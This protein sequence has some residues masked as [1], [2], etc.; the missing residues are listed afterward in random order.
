MNVCELGVEFGV[1]DSGCILAD[2]VGRQRSIR[3]SKLVHETHSLG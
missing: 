2:I 1:Q 3:I